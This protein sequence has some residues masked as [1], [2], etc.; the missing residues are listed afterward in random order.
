M[1]PVI[2]CRHVQQRHVHAKVAPCT[3]TRSRTVVVI[4][5]HPQNLPCTNQMVSDRTRLTG[6][7]LKRPYSRSACVGGTMRCRCAGHLKTS[8]CHL[9]ALMCRSKVCLATPVEAHSKHYR[10][11]M[12]ATMLCVLG[13]HPACSCCHCCMEHIILITAM[14]STWMVHCTAAARLVPLHRSAAVTHLHPPPV[15]PPLDQ[16][17]AMALAPH[18]LRHLHLKAHP[19]AACAAAAVGAA[20]CVAAP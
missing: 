4:R 17:S 5:G 18:L 14:C 15:A 6:S 2:L 3:T 10:S 1:T 13:G 7:C 20:P 8:R 9:Q 11:I 19:V 16:P 12:E